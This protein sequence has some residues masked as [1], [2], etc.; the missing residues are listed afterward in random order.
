MPTNLYGQNDNFNENYSHVIPALINKIKTAK[1]ITLKK[2]HYMEQAKQKESSYVDD[3][4]KA[5]II[6]MNRNKKYSMIN[7]G[8]G[9][10][11]SILNLAKF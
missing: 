1:K 3:L 7:V 5:S 10:E 6:A 9:E 11:I 4:A 2:F 8:S